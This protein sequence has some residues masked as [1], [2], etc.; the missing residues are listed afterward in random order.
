MNKKVSFIIPTYNAKKH[1]ERCLASISKQDYPNDNIEVI[2]ADGLSEDNTVKLA[3]E[4]EVK[5]I[6]N[7]KRDAQIGKAVGLRA[8]KVD[9]DYI[10]IM[11]ADNEIVQ[12]N[13]LSQNIELL[14]SENEVFGADAAYLVNQSDSPMNRV[15]I[16]MRSEDPIVRSFANLRK[17]SHVV[18]KG[19]YEILE[20]KSG[21]FPVFGSGGFIWKGDV[22]RNIIKQINSF[23][24]FDEADVA[25]FTLSLGYKRILCT[26]GVGLYHHHVYSIMGFIKKRIRTGR[27]FILRAEKKRNVENDKMWIKR[28]GRFSFLFAIIYCATFIGPIKEAFAGLAKDGDKAW[29]LL[30]FLSFLAVIV[31]GIVFIL[32]YPRYLLT[33]RG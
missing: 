20:V 17:C 13:W 12:S 31:Y 7:V 1:I 9:A 4:Y 18:N 8:I 14:N 11:D 2:V 25:G 27:E 21:R 5:I 6:E 29:L 16:L 22:L 28:S 24:S 15:A 3:K 19:R 23:D 30:P 32:Y 33:K 10:I 26:G